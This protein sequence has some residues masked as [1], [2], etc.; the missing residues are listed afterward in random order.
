MLTSLTLSSLNFAKTAS[1]NTPE[2]I[3]S[4]AKKMEDN[5][6]KPELEIFDLGMMNFANYLIKK[7][8]LKPPFYFNIILGNIF[9]SQAK[10]AHLA[11]IVSEIPENSIWSIGGIGAQQ[12]RA[13]LL[14]LSQGGGIRTGLEDNIWMDSEKKELASNPKLVSRIHKI[15]DLCNLK[16][17]N[18]HE[19]KS[20]LKI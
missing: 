7:N 2:T 11:S 8:I 10:A 3:I 13:S 20:I 16:M 18:S 12:T 6:I 1:I 5:G 4:L 9:S 14:A 15:G 19:F 17:M